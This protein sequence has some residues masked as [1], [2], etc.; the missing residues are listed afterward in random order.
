MKIIDLNIAATSIHEN[1]K[2]ANNRYLS[3]LK[4][5]SFSKFIM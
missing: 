2:E 4:M 1:N 3:Y 5:D